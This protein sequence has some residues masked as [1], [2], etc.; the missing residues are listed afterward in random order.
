MKS[1]YDGKWKKSI[2]KKNA[3]FQ[4]SRFNINAQ[5]YYCLLDTNGDL[6]VSPKAYDLNVENFIDFLQKGLDEFK[7]K[8]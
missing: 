5:P 3:D 4:I 6:L 8:N 1:E 2:G 7:K